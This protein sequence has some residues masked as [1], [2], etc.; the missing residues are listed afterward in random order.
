MTDLV[1]ATRGMETTTKFAAWSALYFVSAFLKRDAWLPWILGSP[2]FANLYVLFVAPPRICAKSTAVKFATKAAKK[3]DAID[4]DPLLQYVKKLNTHE[5]KATMEVLYDILAPESK[6]FSIDGG[7][8]I[9]VDRG[10]Q[11][12]LIQSELSTFLSKAQYNQTLVPALTKWYDSDE[13]DDEATRGGGRKSLRNIYVTLFGATTPDAMKDDL[14]PEVIGGGF[15]SRCLTITESKST[16]FFPLPT[17]FDGAPDQLELAQRLM[18]I[19]QNCQGPFTLSREAMKVYT[20]W[21]RHFKSSLEKMKED[22]INTRARMD[23]N[24]IKVSMCIRAQRYEPGMIITEQDMLYAIKLID[25]VYNTASPVLDEVGG[26]DGYQHL[27]KVERFVKAN[28]SVPRAKLLGI[29][30]KMLN[31]VQMDGVLVNLKQLGKVY[32]TD[33]N[34]QMQD[35]P[36]SNPSDLIVW[37]GD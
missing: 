25:E 3:T 28:A 30:A 31:N 32:F 15:L 34:G 29:F 6:K 13:R 24:L 14:P 21:Y 11:V 9:M 19:A 22:D 27:K 7:E 23:T 2:M 12:A 37:R 10:S 5:G 1:W 20:K 17:H 4:H 26:T 18:W 8:D 33:K 36:G 35:V 16:R